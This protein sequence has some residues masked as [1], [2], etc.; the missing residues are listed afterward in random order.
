MALFDGG[1]L[2][3][4]KIE[5]SEHTCPEKSTVERSSPIDQDLIIS[6]RIPSPVFYHVACPSSQS[7]NV[8]ADFSHGRA[9]RSYRVFSRANRLQLEAFILTSG[10][11]GDFHQ[12]LGTLPQ[13]FELLSLARMK[14]H[15]IVR[16]L[17][18][19]NPNLGADL[20]TASAM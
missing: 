6:D 7:T 15:R 20:R 4:H 11:R 13:V 1:E 5:R 14:R 12:S 18:G 9:S 17:P 2:T 16:R 19:S 3:L 10:P 8:V